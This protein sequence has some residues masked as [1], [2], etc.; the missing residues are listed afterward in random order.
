VITKHL[1]NGLFSSDFRSLACL[2]ALLFLLPDTTDGLSSKEIRKAVRKAIK[3]GDQ[4]LK[5][6]KKELR[7]FKEKGIQS[8]SFFL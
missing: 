4:T 6:Y 1:S 2:A 3:A 8:F 7:K 5:N